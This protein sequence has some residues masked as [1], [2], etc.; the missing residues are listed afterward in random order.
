MLE[1]AGREVWK[2][3]EDS[4]KAAECDSHTFFKKRKEN[5]V[6]K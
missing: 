2:E 4:M 5:W 1:A 6:H 3:N